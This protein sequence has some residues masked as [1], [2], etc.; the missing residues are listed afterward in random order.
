[1][2]YNVMDICTGIGGFSLALKWL[3]GGFRT[4]CYVEINKYC[5]QVIKQRIRDGYLDDAPI[6]SDL[7]T[8]DGRAWCG[9]VDIITAGFPCQ[10][11]STAAH[12]NWT[13]EDLWPYIAKIINKVKPPIL[14]LG[15]VS[16]N[17]ILKASNDITGYNVK[18]LRIEAAAVGAPHKRSRWMLVA[19]TDDYGQ[20]NGSINDETQIMQ[21]IKTNIWENYTE[22]MG[23]DDGVSHRMDRLKALGNAVVPEVVRQTWKINNGP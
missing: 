14:F 5:Q 8:L 16:K 3:V 15:N 18:V 2:M 10:A 1:M 7:K 21:K 19:H 17:P 11:F 22:V 23:M 13:A 20:S 4:V 9:A 6:W 12:G